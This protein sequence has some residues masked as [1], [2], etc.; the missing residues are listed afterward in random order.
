MKVFIVVVMIIILPNI[1]ICLS[2]KN[3]NSNTNQNKTKSKTSI[4][5]SLVLFKNLKH[6]QAPQVN[7]PSN[8][9]DPELLPM[10]LNSVIG[11]NKNPVSDTNSL[12]GP[13]LWKGWVKFFKYPQDQNHNSPKAFYEN[14]EYTDQLKRVKQCD[15]EVKEDGVWKFPIH[16][17]L[18]YCIIYNNEVSFSRSKI[19]FLTTIY[20]TLKIDYIQPVSED[21]GFIGGIT[22]VGSFKEGECFKVSTLKSGGWNWIIC[23]DESVEKFKVMN[24]LKKVVINHQR[25][26]GTVFVGTEKPEQSPIK[27]N[28]LETAKSF[29][30]LNDNSN[31]NKPKTSYWEVL[32]D[33]STCS[34]FCG[35]GTQTLQRICV[36]IKVGEACEGQEILTKPCN[37]KPCPVDDRKIN[38][39]DP[40]NKKK[41]IVNNKKPVLK[42]LPFSDRPQRYDKCHLKESDLLLT[43]GLNKAPSLNQSMK[44]TAIQIPVRVIMNEHTI[45]AY[46]GL[47]ETDKKVSFDIKKVN[48]YHS[49]RDP[50]C[51][52]LKEIGVSDV[53]GEIGAIEVFPNKAEFCPFGS[54][55]NGPEIKE[56]WDYDFHLFKNQ[57]HQD[58]KVS[59]VLDEAEIEKELNNKKEAIKIDLISN[60]K[61]KIM[62]QEVTK[63][64]THLKE[65]KKESLQALKQEMKLEEL[66]EQ[67]IKEVQNQAFEQKKEELEKEKQKLD[68]LNKAI[69][70]KELETEYSIDIATRESRVNSIKKQVADTIIEKR[71]RLKNKIAKLKKLNEFKI[72]TMDTQIKNIRLEMLNGLELPSYNPSLCKIIIETKNELQYETERKKYCDMKMTHDPEDYAKCKSSNRNDL[73]QLCCDYETDPNK[74]E[75]F[76]EC[77]KEAE[78][79]KD[80]QLNDVRFFWGRPYNRLQELH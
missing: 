10:D 12:N 74:P 60:K 16:K 55:S 57:C 68:C 64:S 76:K 15:L 80:A 6:S 43:V 22:N 66:V 21:N 19:N 2:T 11:I 78:V 33:W 62:I 67:E 47:K 4:F 58:K 41:V 56:E 50:M 45:S 26:N 54:S 25:K 48:F 3:H 79:P 69:R 36:Q 13:I 52:E 27:Q 49:S 7:P 53:A 59:A 39:L 40:F 35:G 18:F 20:D 32:Q 38:I 28:G 70:E 73:I 31:Q 17:N 34:K 61:A 65:A 9:F 42:V 72:G 5:E 75:D 1:L 71:E 14:L 51:F 8:P 37:T 46:A 63:P 24:E 44:I 23:T 30:D 77:I 29:T